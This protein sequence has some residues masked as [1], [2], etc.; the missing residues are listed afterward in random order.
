MYY[1]YL[2]V[3]LLNDYSVYITIYIPQSTLI[4]QHFID[5]KR[6]LNTFIPP[7]FCV[8]FCRTFTLF[9]S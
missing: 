9:I 4:L 8:I 1:L 6:I 5:S 2:F 7:A 3:L